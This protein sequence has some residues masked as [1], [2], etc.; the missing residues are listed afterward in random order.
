M[1]ILI[2]EDDPFKM[3]AITGVIGPLL[4]GKPIARATSLRSA[5]AMIE[6]E[7]FDFVILDMAIPSH[8]SEVGAI[9]T[10]SQPVGGLDILLY[11][12][13]GHRAERVAILTQYPTVEYDRKH[14]LLHE[15][16]MI[17][18]RDEVTNVVDVIR[19]DDDRDDWKDRI[20]LALGDIN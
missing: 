10:Y 8:T 11:L 17:L 5:M 1:R 18:E 12:A 16:K 14:V 13:F 3:T 15:F 4:N 6:A 7:S 9:D 20:I 19:F 2:V